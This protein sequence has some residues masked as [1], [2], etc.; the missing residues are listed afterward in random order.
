M[1]LKSTARFCRTPY[2]AAMRGTAMRPLSTSQS[3]HGTSYAYGQSY[4][5]VSELEYTAV[6][7]IPINCLIKIYYQSKELQFPIFLHHVIFYIMS[8]YHNISIFFWIVIVKRALVCLSSPRSPMS[9]VLSIKFWVIFGNM[10]LTWPAL[11]PDLLQR[12]NN[13]KLIWRTWLVI[14]FNMTLFYLSL[15]SSANNHT[16]SSAN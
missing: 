12:K 1:L 13:L 9:L 11:N 5:A 3:Q 6:I 16:S 14:Q 2:A 15:I 4:Q 7:S 8:N 10:T